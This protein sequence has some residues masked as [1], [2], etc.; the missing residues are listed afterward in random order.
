MDMTQVS[1]ALESALTLHQ[2]GNL[3]EAQSLYREIVR[4]DPFDSDALHLLGVTAHQQGRNDEAADY[5]F[6]AIAIRPMVAEFHNNLG[7]VLHAMSRSEEA[8][9][10]YEEAIRLAP[11]DADS[12]FNAL[13]AAD[14][15]PAGTRAS[16]ARALHVPG[17]GAV[18][19][20]HRC[21]A[22]GGGPEPR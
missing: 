1:N 10:A 11:D 7:S 16:T 5:I 19:G 2:S 17:R 4:D 13:R 14:L 12:H 8:V 20:N 21:R 6:Q 22:H 15:E 3:Q 9:A 18:D